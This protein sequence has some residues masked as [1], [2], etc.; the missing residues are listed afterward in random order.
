MTALSD[1]QRKMIFIKR[2]ISLS[3]GSRCCS[4]HLYKRHISYESLWQINDS[5]SDHFVFN[6]DDVKNL[7]ENFRTTIQTAKRFDFDDPHCLPYES[8]FNITSFSK[9]GS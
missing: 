2:G 3:K 5:I 1:C 8:Y 4:E 7:I 6:C 9:K